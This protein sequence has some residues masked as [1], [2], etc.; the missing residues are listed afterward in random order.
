VTKS[1][2]RRL[3]V[4]QTNAEEPE[5]P[6]PAWH[7]VGFGAVAI[8][9][10]WLPLAYF[11]ESIGRRLAQSRLNGASVESLARADRVAV[12]ARIALPQALALVLAGACGGF[13]V[14]RFGRTTKTRDAALAGLVVGAL[15]L[16]LTLPQTG[17]SLAVLAVPMLACASAA[18][19]GALGA[20]VITK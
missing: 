13:L 15:A 5:E 11:A 6:R 14:T 2:K 20:K 7:W 10:A 3:P 19:G 17:F 18:A 12:L 8:F 9:V 16:G 4:L 1:D